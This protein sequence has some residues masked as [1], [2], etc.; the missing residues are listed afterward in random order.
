MQDRILRHRVR[1]RHRHRRILHRFDAEDEPLRIAH[2]IATVGRAAVV[3]HHDGDGGG[4]VGVGCGRERERAAR[5]D[6]GLDAEKVCVR[7]GDDERDGL[8]CFRR[9]AD[10]DVRR[11]PGEGEGAGILGD[12]D[13]L[14]QLRHAGQGEH[15]AATHVEDLGQAGCRRVQSRGAP[16]DERSIVAHG[17]SAKARRTDGDDV[18]QVR[19]R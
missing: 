6:P 5:A 18:S 15:G 17:Q 4:A 3:H 8:R 16:G 11:G 13:R 9:R 12:R 19:R 1:V 2:V 14:Q 7:R 10:G